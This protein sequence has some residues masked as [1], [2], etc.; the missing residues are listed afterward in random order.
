MWKLY[1][2]DCFEWMKEQE[3]NQFVAIVTDPPYSLEEFNRENL[4]KM[5]RGS[6]GLW[7]IPPKIGGYER[8]PLPRFTVFSPE[9]RK[10]MYNY[11]YE[12]AKLAYKVLVPGGHLVIASTPIFLPTVASAIVDAGFE[13]RGIIVRLVQTLR[14]GFRPKNA[15]DEYEDLCTMPRAHYEPWALLRKP[16]EKGLTVAENLRKWKA[17]ALRRDP[18]GRP[19]PDV[20]PSERT[21]EKERI[22]AP[23]PTLKPQSFMRRI[24][25]A[26]VPMGEGVVLD[27]FSGA[28]S[29]LAAAEALGYD[30][31]GVE[32]N[33]E[34]Y[35]MALHAVPEL[36][37]L[38]VD[39]WFFERKVKNSGKTLA[40]TSFLLN[41]T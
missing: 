24:V 13:L 25:W 10:I 38:E 30:S 6:G 8:S 7:R 3:P 37:K 26:V 40:L 4:E 31:V 18:D 23:H 32:V 20:I 9:H 17:G 2:A 41:E 1:L 21:P 27:P 16:L 5:K 34:Y 35:E 29:T 36:A 14:G 22:I 39:P 15:E 19:L 12:W 11:F 28:G 33:P